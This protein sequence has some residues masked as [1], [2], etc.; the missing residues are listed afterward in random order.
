M[1]SVFQDSA[2]LELRLAPIGRGISY[3][4]EIKVTRVDKRVGR[5][6]F[7]CNWQYVQSCSIDI[8]VLGF[9]KY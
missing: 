3:Y 9:V 8:E 4:G 6:V 2:A 1:T 7:V 5:Y